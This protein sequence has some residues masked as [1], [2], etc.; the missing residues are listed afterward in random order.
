MQNNREG[1]QKGG[2]GE[3]SHGCKALVTETACDWQKTKIMKQTQRVVWLTSKMPLWCVETKIINFSKRCFIYQKYMKRPWLVFCP[4]PKWR[5]KEKSNWEEVSNSPWK[6]S[7]NEG[8]SNF[9]C[10]LCQCLLI[11]GTVLQNLQGSKYVSL[12]LNFGVTGEL[13]MYLVL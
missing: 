3:A 12:E 1:T 5:N 6:C 10:C 13:V 8:K 4:S 7:V 2:I 11:L 9:S